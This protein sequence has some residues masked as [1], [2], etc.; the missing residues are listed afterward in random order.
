[1]RKG[2]SEMKPL[3]KE[4]AAEIKAFLLGTLSQ[5]CKYDTWIR[6]QRRKA[7]RDWLR[8]RTEETP[9]KKAPTP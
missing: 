6:Q 3:T 1:M 9:R 2:R 4:Q 7:I 8:E 5:Y